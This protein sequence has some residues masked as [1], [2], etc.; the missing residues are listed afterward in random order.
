[1]IKLN[2]IETQADQVALVLFVLAGIIYAIWYFLIRNDDYQ[3]GLY[4]VGG[5]VLSLF[6]SWMLT[7]LATPVTVSQRDFFVTFTVFGFIF[8]WIMFKDED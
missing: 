4:I 2:I 7:I 5:I 1:M 8:L 3:S 6:E